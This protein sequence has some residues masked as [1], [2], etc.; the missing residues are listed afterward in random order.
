MYD[1]IEKQIENKTTFKF[2]KLDSHIS[3][4]AP[5]RLRR[6]ASGLCIKNDK[7]DQKIPLWCIVMFFYAF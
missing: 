1:H 3:Q 4:A 2:S 7:N 6:G 5:R